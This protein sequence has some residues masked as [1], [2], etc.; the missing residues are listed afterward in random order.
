MAKAPP[1]RRP[2]VYRAGSARVCGSVTVLPLAPGRVL[3]VRLAGRLTSVAA[4][5]WADDGVAPS[6]MAGLLIAETVLASEPAALGRALLYE[7][8]YGYGDHTVTIRFKPARRFDPARLQRAIAAGCEDGMECAR[9]DE[10]HTAVGVTVWYFPDDAPAAGPLLTVT[11]VS[12]YASG[13]EATPRADDTAAAI[14]IFHG[15]RLPAEDGYPA[16]DADP[17]PEDDDTV[18][19]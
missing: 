16:H 11:P 2:S 5:D 12:R 3:Q 18:P 8:S 1:P 10:G 17:W 19:E 7:H 4:M 6:D 13:P 15:A 14:Q 9:G